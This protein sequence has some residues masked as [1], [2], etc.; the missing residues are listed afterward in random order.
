MKNMNILFE[1]KMKNMN[2]LFE[3]KIK[4]MNRFSVSMQICLTAVLNKLN[5][6]DGKLWK[7][8]P[9]LFGLPMVPILC[10]RK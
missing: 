5:Y 8:S 1:E 3:E 6:V 7:F 10:C 4:K 9:F 2:L